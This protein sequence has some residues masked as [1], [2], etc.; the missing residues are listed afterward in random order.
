[1]NSPKRLSLPPGFDGILA[2]GLAVIIIL[3]LHES[4]KVIRTEQL[5]PLLVWAP[6]GPLLLAA[7]MWRPER[8]P[9]LPMPR[10]LRP[11]A[12]LAVMMLAALMTGWSYHR[13]FYFLRWNQPTWPDLYAG[14][15]IAVAYFVVAAL[16][17]PI[18]IR[19]RRWLPY[20][21]AALLVVTMARC[22]HALYLNSGWTL[23]T[24]D[25]HPSFI[26]RIWKVGEVYP[27]LRSYVPYW[28]GG[29]I[30]AYAIDSGTIGPAL[31][32]YPFIKWFTLEKVYTPAIGVLFIVVV[33]LLGIWAARI[34]GA[35]RSGQIAAGFLAL[36]TTPYY[37]LWLMQ[38]GTVGANFAAAFV[39]P[40]GACLYRITYHHDR[41]WRLG[42]STVI[43][44]IFLTTWPP[45]LLMA[46]IITLGFLVNIRHWTWPKWRF[47]ILC[48]VAALIVQARQL[49]TLV[50]ADVWQVIAPLETPQGGT[51]A[52]ATHWKALWT[53]GYHW[54][55]A[56]FRQAHPMILL[57][58]LCGGLVIRYRRLRAF[59]GPILIGLM[60]LTALGSGV[61][62]ILQL[63]RMIIPLWFA[64]V[65][66]AAILT[67][68][69]LDARGAHW[70]FLRAALL[71]MILLIGDNA[72]RMWDNE[73][74]A[75]YQGMTPD[76]EAMVDHIR[77]QVPPD[78]RLLFAGHTAHSYGGGHV[79]FLPYLTGREMMACDY[80]H[81]DPAQV[82]YNYPPR[83]WR[84]NPERTREFLRLYNVALVAS[85]RESWIN[86]FRARPDQY[87]E[88]A[89][90]R[91][92]C[93]V[94]FRVRDAEPSFLLEGAGRTESHFNRIRV[95]L[96]EESE[97]VVLSYN[98]H[99]DLRVDPP[100]ELFP[101]DAGPGV[102]LIGI[103]PGGLRELTLRY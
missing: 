89:T 38:Y 84:R 98:W 47:L 10:A 9:F 70:A 79:A 62:P 59:Y 66:P 63:E 88:T 93:I 73:S 102:R 20:A 101:V 42:L 5:L 82:E 72:V 18:F 75:R 24:R 87:E 55:Q 28:N 27:R 58:G 7:R 12:V 57:L 76:I 81:F 3:M 91:D 1:M 95:W 21:L 94:F 92:G 17:V 80:Y 2:F 32:M 49:F 53:D 25:D 48:G 61:M 23:L 15:T 14:S 103:R 19:P 77:E 51:T 30:H 16:L 39:M 97:R 44:A 71:A 22:F 6:I 65:V 83:A 78:A 69:L 45:G 96:D 37:Y 54:L 85:R 60:L 26:F 11:G 99:P 35:R 36:L 8:Y 50:E 67:G 4:G 33:P 52:V 46:G 64:A 29:E 41:S 100:A 74:L 13:W 43:S 31:L 56:H 40:F 86:F 68:R 34:A 90:F